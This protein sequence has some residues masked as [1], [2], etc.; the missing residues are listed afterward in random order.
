MQ[1]M[2]LEE[3]K[4]K[5]KDFPKVFVSHLLA[6][7]RWSEIVEQILRLNMIQHNNHERS[8]EALR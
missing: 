3:W 1:F 8:C 6:R 4:D 5:I 2:D 7:C